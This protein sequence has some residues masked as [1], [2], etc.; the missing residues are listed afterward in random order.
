MPKLFLQQDFEGRG[1][2]DA[3]KTPPHLC[4]QCLA[5]WVA[6]ALAL[7]DPTDKSF[8]DGQLCRWVAMGGR[9]G[10]P[11]SWSRCFSCASYVR[12]WWVARPVV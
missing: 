4:C 6:S 5:V 11:G 2:V 7:S 9:A 12:L 8:A 1:I 3:R 10:A